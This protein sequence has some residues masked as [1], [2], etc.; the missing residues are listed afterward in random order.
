MKRMT[1]VLACMVLQGCVSI[2]LYPEYMTNSCIGLG[3][4]TSC[5]NPAKAH[6]TTGESPAR[7]QIDGITR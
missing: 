6:D 3:C 7:H 4:T 1:V 5:N 2:T